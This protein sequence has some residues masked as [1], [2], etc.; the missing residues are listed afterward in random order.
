MSHKYT[1]TL[2]NSG[3]RIPSDAISQS[4]LVQETRILSATGKHLHKI[5]KS[6]TS[7]LNGIP[8]DCRHVLRILRKEAQE[9]F[10]NF[11][12]SIP[13]LSLADRMSSYLHGLTLSSDT[14]PLA[15]SV[16]ICARAEDTDRRTSHTDTIG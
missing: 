12:E 3:G 8:S 6:I 10:T 11:G 9:Y 1:V 5:D 2:Y 7:A 4:S 14:R 13:L 16:I 15:V